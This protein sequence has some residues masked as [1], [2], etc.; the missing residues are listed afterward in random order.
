MI[1]RNCPLDSIP[2]SGAGRRRRRRSHRLWSVLGAILLMVAAG[3]STVRPGEVG[4]KQ[5]LGRL[6]DEGV[7]VEPV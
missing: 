1:P 6:G 5:T 4:V 7:L 2:T 3:C